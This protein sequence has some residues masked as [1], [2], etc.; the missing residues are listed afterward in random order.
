MAGLSVFIDPH[1]TH[2]V[3]IE[4][5]TFA[6]RTL[7][8]REMFRVE[9]ATAGFRRKHNA[10]VQAARKKATKAVDYL[11][12]LR[13]KSIPVS[14]LSAERA[15]EREYARVLGERLQT[16]RDAWD[17]KNAEGET[18]MKPRPELF[19]VIEMEGVAFEDEDLEALQEVLRIGI[20]TW[21]GGGAPVGDFRVEKIE[22]CRM[23]PE[24]TLDL[25]RPDWWAPIYEDLMRLNRQTDDQRAE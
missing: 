24:E 5:T 23:I 16:A 20:V 3:V 13:G 22:G 17:E 8:A 19:D 6:L 9:K 12:E 21:E 7:T 15:D 25:V 11:E 4:G 18:P 10:A 1:E 2:N 14:E